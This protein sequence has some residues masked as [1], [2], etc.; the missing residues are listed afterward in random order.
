[1]PM[2]ETEKKTGLARS[3]VGDD[4]VQQEAG[5]YDSNAENRPQSAPLDT[6]T[7]TFLDYLIERTLL[8]CI[9]TRRS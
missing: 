1:M 9:Q 3:R 5:P 7:L 6:A 2:N 4:L 8:Q